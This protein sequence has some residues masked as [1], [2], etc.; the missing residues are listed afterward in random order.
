MS[1]SRRY[2]GTR[3][4]APKQFSLFLL[5]PS[6]IR[7][8]PVDRF[9]RFAGLRRAM[10]AHGV[11]AFGVDGLCEYGRVGE[12]KLTIKMPCFEFGRSMLNSRKKTFVEAKS[13]GVK[14]ITLT[15]RTH[16]GNARRK[17]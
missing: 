2:T 12:A 4:L 14:S 10:R 17:F 1:D 5:L 7:L 6:R 13:V 3:A 16:S 8:S 11:G 9:K 15:A